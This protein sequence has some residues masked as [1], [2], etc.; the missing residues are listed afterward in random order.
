MES[1][2]LL[3]NNNPDLAKLQRRIAV[4]MD[5]LRAY[6]KKSI[7]SCCCR[8]PDRD[9]TTLSDEDL[10][11]FAEVKTNI[12]SL[13]RHLT[14]SNLPDGNKL[15]ICSRKLDQQQLLASKAHVLLEKV[16]L[17]LSQLKQDELNWNYCA[18]ENK[19]EAEM[20]PMH[21]HSYLHRS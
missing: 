17:K 1:R 14:E 4:L 16:H 12:A 11:I 13:A 10:D 5:R 8:Q 18:I 20:T 9:M 3:A 2:P 15:I 21:L 7:F 6:Q 19:T